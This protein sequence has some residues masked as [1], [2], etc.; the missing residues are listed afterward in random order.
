MKIK[1][2]VEKARERVARFGR[3]I[4]DSNLI[5]GT[6]GNI[7]C[8]LPDEQLVIITPSG[9]GYHQIRPNMPV[10]VNMD[11]EVREGDLKPS[12]EIKVHLAIYAAREDVNAVVHTH[13]AYASALAVSGISI[14]PIL[15]DMAAL[16]GGE[17]PV[18]EYAVAGSEQ[19]ARSTVRAMGKK[20]A[21]LLANHGMVGVG[22]DLD[23]AFDVCMMVERC[24]QIYIISKLVGD[25]KVLSPGDVAVLRDF[26]LNK[27]GQRERVEVF[28]C[29]K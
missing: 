21:V 2:T 25:P 20:N 11:G 9:V 27:Y 1:L 6:W 5:L 24:A 7:S 17:V 12:S 15:E 13:S 4:A 14:P 8:R 3:K 22:R 26:Y 19:L 28:K 18:A 29:P 10:V 16:I 23:E